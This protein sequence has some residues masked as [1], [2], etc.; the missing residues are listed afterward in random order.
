MHSEPVEGE[1]LSQEEYVRRALDLYRRM[2]G[3]LGHVRRHDRVVATDLHRRRVPLAVVESAL[4]LAAVRR[5]LRAGDAAPLAPVR[6]L[7]Y[8]LPVI[9]EAIATP[10]PQDY[11]RYLRDKLARYAT[12]M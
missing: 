1:D 7:A 8:F 9:E 12:R 10:L 3:T 2:P 5:T 4:V 6:S 11:I